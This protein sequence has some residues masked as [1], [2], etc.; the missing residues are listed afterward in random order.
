MNVLVVFNIN[1]VYSRLCTYLSCYTSNP[2]GAWHASLPEEKDSDSAKSSA[3][4]TVHAIIWC[5]L[6]FP[7]ATS[8]THYKTSNISW[9][10]LSQAFAER[11]LSL[12]TLHYAFC[13]AAVPQQQLKLSLHPSVQCSWCVFILCLLLTILRSSII[14]RKIITVEYV[15]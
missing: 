11:Y 13:L 6:S 12:S 5:A 2:C 9:S 1:C 15:L 8:N 7:N 10:I 3:S 4:T 14:Q